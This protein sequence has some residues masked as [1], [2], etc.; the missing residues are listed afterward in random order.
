[1]LAA[2]TMT[3]T[4]SSRCALVVL[5]TT[6]LGGAQAAPRS[7]PLVNP[8]R[9]GLEAAKLASLKGELQK[10]IDQGEIAGAIAVIGRKGTVGVFDVV[11]QAD[12]AG[13]KPMRAETMFR[14]ASMTKIATAVAVMMLEDD[15]KLTV[16]DPVQKHLPEFR[17]QK[18]LKGDAAALAA[19]GPFSLVDP[20]RP[21]TIKDL[22]THTSG[23]NCRLPAG[24]ADLYGKRDRTL[25][26]GAI[27]FSQHPLIGPPGVTWKYCSPAYDTLG[28]I[29]EVA[30]GKAYDVFMK[31]RLFVPLG[32]TDT[33][34]QPS[35]EQRKRLAVVYEKKG[36]ALVVL[37]GQGN[38]AENLR[39]FSPSGGI[40]TT[41]SDYA[42]LGQMLLD[43]GRFAGRQLL[44]EATWQ[45][46]TSV[47]FTS[48]E[49]VGFS[50]G[51]GMGLGVQVVMQPTDITA[52]L[53][54]GSFGHGGAYG[55]QLWV[56]PAHE[57]YFLLM[58]QR[59]H[60]DGDSSAAR[61]LVQ[62]I[63]T[64]AILPAS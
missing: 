1:M 44:R 34:F 50:P 38:P 4:R 46:M 57:M 8:A 12:L 47:Q 52:A 43:R 27:A 60:Y 7:A 3:S 16:D 10:L 19:G 63:G 9:A 42:R 45:K 39:W 32:M 61:K 53:G 2:M 37:D 35:A 31:Q 30:S 6:C 20:P 23:M 48:K 25:A 41:A 40:F 28:R 29:I 18:M 14:I 33:T 17:G 49:K 62:S 24:F 11:G 5:L 55:T 51:L 13:H 54:K 59:A 58:V 64:A 21:I 15:G 36:D 56:D 26:E 22:I